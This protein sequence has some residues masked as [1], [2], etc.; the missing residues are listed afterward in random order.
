MLAFQER[1][2]TFRVMGKTDLLLY[3]IS[4]SCEL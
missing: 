4:Y 3:L 1:K 2:E